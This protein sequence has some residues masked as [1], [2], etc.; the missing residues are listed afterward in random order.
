MAT[1]RKTSAFK[2]DSAAS[3]Q[4]LLEA[5]IDVF[6]AHGFNATTTRMVGKKAGLNAALIA[7]Y[8]GSK[9]KLLLAVFE[10]QKDAFFSQDLPPLLPDLEDELINYSKAMF[11]HARMNTKA[12][13]IIGGFAFTNA[14]FRK[15]LQKDAI[16]NLDRHLCERFI[17]MKKAGVFPAQAKVEQVAKALSSYFIGQVLL[18]HLIFEKPLKEIEEET[19]TMIHFFASLGAGAGR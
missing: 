11:E 3:K 4:R 5:A 7:R 9:E 2:R 18:N 6:S 15:R 1:P 10:Q 13:R 14:Q 19:R 8:F 17:D 12:M 16:Q